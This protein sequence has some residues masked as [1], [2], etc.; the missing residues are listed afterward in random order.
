MTL[1]IATHQKI[2]EDL[3]VSSFLSSLSILE[4]N[5]LQDVEL[6]KIFSCRLYLLMVAFA[7]QKLFS[8]T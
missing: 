7:I 8:F 6:V 2:G 5:S 1:N 4:V 3:L